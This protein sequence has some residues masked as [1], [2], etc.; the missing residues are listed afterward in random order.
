[1]P[2]PMK[3]KSPQAV[4][5]QQQTDELLK[6]AIEQ[7]GLKEAIEVYEALEPYNRAASE[8]NSVYERQ[9]IPWFFTSSSCSMPLA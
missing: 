2:S 4:Q 8:F 7:P 6:K 1:M 9:Q 3:T 5:S